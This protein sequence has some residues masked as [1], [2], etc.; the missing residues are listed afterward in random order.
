MHMHISTCLLIYFLSSKQNTPS[1]MISVIR[2]CLEAKEL[3]GIKGL[4]S[5]VIKILELNNDHLLLLTLAIE[6]QK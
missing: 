3:E 5:L 2:A 4:Q 1:S 6:N